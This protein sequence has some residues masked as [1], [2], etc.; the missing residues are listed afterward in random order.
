LDL[1]P[2]E[3][4]SSMTMNDSFFTGLNYWNKLAGADPGN[5]YVVYAGDESLTRS[6]ANVVSWKNIDQI[7]PSSSSRAS[8]MPITIVPPA[9]LANAITVFT[10]PARIMGIL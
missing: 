5:S 2:V 6:K 10:I 4:K 3:I 9:V 8:A 7:R 1:T